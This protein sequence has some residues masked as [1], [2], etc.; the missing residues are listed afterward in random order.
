MPYYLE[1]LFPKGIYFN[2]LIT[3]KPPIG[4]WVTPIISASG[5]RIFCPSLLQL[6]IKV[7]QKWEFLPASKL[8]KESKK[9]HKVK[10]HEVVGNT[11]IYDP[12]ALPPTTS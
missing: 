11:G 3:W 12:A 1:R 5:G 9:R 6:T 8:R 10:R 4:K 7:F 2:Y